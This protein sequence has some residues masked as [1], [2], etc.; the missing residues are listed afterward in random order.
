VGERTIRADAGGQDAVLAELVKNAAGI[1]AGTF[2]LDVP[3]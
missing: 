1:I 2:P 3:V